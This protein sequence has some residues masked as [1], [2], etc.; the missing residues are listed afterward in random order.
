MT[1]ANWITVLVTL[2][3]LAATWGEVRARLKAVEKMANKTAADL[4]R[5]LASSRREQ[6]ARIGGVEEDRKSVV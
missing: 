2:V 5:N 6:G 1:T 3:A 4:E